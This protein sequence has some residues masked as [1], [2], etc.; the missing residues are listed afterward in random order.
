M[1]TSDMIEAAKVAAGLVGLYLAYRAVSEVKKNGVAGAA[2][3][4]VGVAG[5][6]A[7][8]AVKGVGSLF[9]IPDTDTTRCA[10]AK[11]SG[12]AWDVSL[13]CPAS[14][15]LSYTFTGGGMPPSRIATQADTAAHLAQL[16][17]AYGQ[18]SFSEI[19]S[20]QYDPFKLF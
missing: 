12:S 15:F 14:D 4:V 6:A 16:D 17:A 10:A 8:G 9:G 19:S 18:R 11:A 2:A 13:Y 3:A 20:G 7:V 5:D 1:K